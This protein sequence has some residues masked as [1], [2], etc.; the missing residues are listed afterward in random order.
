MS[1]KGY[2]S[3]VTEPGK[4]EEMHCKVCGS[5]CDV[6]RGVL[7][8]TSFMEAMGRRGKMHD[9]FQ[10]PYSEQPWHKQA[11]RLVKEI[12]KSPSPRLIELMRQDLEDILKA[13]GLQS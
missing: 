4:Q 3:F 2:D 7:G 1:E 9:M 5:L 11:L 6:E 10:C 13:Y 12:E 8:P